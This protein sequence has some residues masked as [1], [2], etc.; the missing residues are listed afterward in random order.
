MSMIPDFATKLKYIKV[1]GAISVE[2]ASNFRLY[3]TVFVLLGPTGSGKSSFI[4]AVASNPSLGL[5]SHKLEGF[6]Q[7]VSIYQIINAVMPLQSPIYLV[8]V[9]GFADSKISVMSIVSMLKDM[10]QTNKELYSF[11]ILYHTPIN[12]PRLPGSQRQ[13]LRT[14]EALTGP[15][16]AGRVTVVSTMWDSI[17]NENTRR[18]AEGNFSQLRK[19]IWKDYIVRGAGILKFHNTQ[20]SALAILD[21]A[22][23]RD[24]GAFNQFSIVTSTHLP[25]RELPFASHIYNDLQS[26]IH[27]L[28]MQQVNIQS[29]LQMATEQSD[30]ELRVVLIAQLAEV[31][32]LFT[33]FEEELQQFEAPPDPPVI[34]EPVPSTENSASPTPGPLLTPGST[35]STQ[36][37]LALAPGVVTPA[38]SELV[39]LTP[40][41]KS[42]KGGIFMRATNRVKGWGNKLSKHRAS[43]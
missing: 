37:P 33:K 19:E 5:S 15:K 40:D 28:Q 26:R 22:Y 14:F 24:I 12:N 4:E 3:G 31:Q 29:E 9:P 25:L 34:L 36:G 11:R 17:W 41:S 18:R 42:P 6:T 32:I 35:T 1:L 10:I 7:S 13:V 8:D 38:G 23:G 27:D 20:E 21:N 39:T 16:S 43:D 30:E 2:R